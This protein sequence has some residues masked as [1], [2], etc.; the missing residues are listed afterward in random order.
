MR[1]RP[2]AVIVSFMTLANAAASAQTP[3]ITQARDQ[4]LREYRRTLAEARELYQG[5]NRGVEQTDTVSRKV[6]IG[7]SG[8]VTIQNVSGTIVVTAGSGED[9]TIDAVKRAHGDRSELDRV[10]IVIEEHPGRVDVRTDYRGQGFFGGTNASVDYTV[11]VPDGASVDLKSISGDVKVTGV[12]GSVRIQSISGSVSA[13]SAPRVEFAKT[14]S[15]NIDLS[16]VAFDGDL[17][18]SSISGDVRAM[19]LKTRSLDVNTVSGD[20]SLREASCERFNARSISGSVEYSGALET[21]GR[22][23]VN[24]H[25]GGVR[26]TLAGSTGFELNASSFSGGIR[27]D[28]PLTIGGEKNP[29]VRSGGRRRGP[30]DSILGTFG[31]GSARLTLHTFSGQIVIGKR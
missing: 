24:S 5:R 2:I 17:T 1:L 20:V 22:Y 28:F 9:A 7:R 14:V 13:V 19:G 10:G 3:T 12:K 18:A 31:D 23:E 15:G 26:F 21:N 8:Q 11:V 25:S 4:A 30:G 6:R 27:S 16:G 29:D